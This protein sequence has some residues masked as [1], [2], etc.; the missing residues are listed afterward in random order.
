MT[1]TEAA[2]VAPPPHAPLS[3]RRAAGRDTARIIIFGQAAL[4][5]IIAILYVSSKAFFVVDLAAFVGAVILLWGGMRMGADTPMDI[6]SREEMS[7][8][9][10]VPWD[11]TDVLIAIPAAFTASSVLVSLFV[12]LTDALTNGVDSTVRT[13]VESI[14]EQA[15]FYAGA[16]F[17]IWVLVGLRRGGSL[18]HLGWRRFSWWWVIIAFVAAGAT[19]YIADLLQLVSQHLFP[20][21]SNTQ[22]VAVQHDYS[23]FLWLAIIVVCFMAP[24]AEETMFRG[25]MYGW[26]HR[27]MPA[28]FAVVLSGA[29]FSIAHGVLLLFIPL[30]GVGIVLA[31]VFQSSRSL[32]PGALTHALFN[33]P[34]IIA[35]L[36]TPTC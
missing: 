18:Y 25:F 34:G 7:T 10:R 31:I 27:V 24:L 5:V 19:L 21:A 6:P 23:H 28:A 26:M 4:L 12:P 36:S 33:L 16:L 9:R 30:W 13:A 14:V 22:C 3:P 17:N 35:I 20:S 2:L 8:S 32:W 11:W 1:Q 15:A 29:V